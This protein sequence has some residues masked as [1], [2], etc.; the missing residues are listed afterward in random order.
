MPHLMLHW[1]WNQGP[2]A[3]LFVFFSSGADQAMPQDVQLQDPP[4]KMVVE[5][6]LRNP[7]RT[8]QQ[9]MVE[10]KTF[11][12]IYKG[13]ESFQAWLRW[14][15]QVLFGSYQFSSPSIC[16][17]HLF[18]VITPSPTWNLFL[19]WGG[20][21]APCCTM[22]LFILDRPASSC[23]TGLGPPLTNTYKKAFPSNRGSQTSVISAQIAIRGL[24]QLSGRLRKEMYSFL[25]LFLDGNTGLTKIACGALGPCGTVE[26]PPRFGNVGELGQAD[27]QCPSG[28]SCRK[29]RCCGSLGRD[30]LGGVRLLGVGSKGTQSFFF[31]ECF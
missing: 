24:G 4:A 14:K 22:D 27:A 16:K 20:E 2:P 11:V 1:G 10:T 28:A 3:Q 18:L 9:T 6:G 29:V 13:I 7:F 15:P 21:P 26:L 25:L 12:G 23:Y 31:F 8:S 5:G 17:G 19:F 30:F